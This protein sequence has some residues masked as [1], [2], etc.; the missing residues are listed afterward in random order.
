VSELV[1]LSIASSG[2]PGQRSAAVVS[3][4]T[5]DLMILVPRRG[6]GVCGG[7]GSVSAGGPR[8]LQ[9]FSGAEYGRDC[10]LQTFFEGEDRASEPS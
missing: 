2:A 1:R 6:L 4:R 9:Q 7:S 3:F 8:S 5:G 10:L